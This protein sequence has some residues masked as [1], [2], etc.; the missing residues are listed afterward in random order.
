MAEYKKIRLISLARWTSVA[1]LTWLAANCSGSGC[2]SCS[3]MHPIPGGFPLSKR[4]EN[5]IQVRVTKTGVA[6][7]EQHADDILSGLM[8]NG[9]EFNITPT[10]DQD[11]SGFGSFDLCGQGDATHCTADDPPCKTHVELEELH[12]V[13]TAPASVNIDTRV[14]IWTLSSMQ[15][16]GDNWYTPDC[17]I[18]LDTRN[19]SHTDLQVV[20]TLTFNQD[21]QSNRTHMDIASVTIP[22][23]EL[24]DEDVS[25]GGGLACDTVELFFKS[26]I[27]DEVRQKIADQIAPMLNS[28]CITCDATDPQC[29]QLSSCK[30]VFVDDTPDATP[31][32]W[33]MEKSENGCVQGLGME[34]RMDVGSLLS[35]LSPPSE[36]DLDIE[37]WAGGYTEA[38]AEG[39]SQGL[40]AG[41]LPY[42]EHAS[43]VPPRDPP[44]YAQVPRSQVFDTNLRPTDNQPY[45][46]GVGIHQ[47]FLD[48]VGYALY[49]SGGLCLE[50]GPRQST[51]LTMGAIGVL[52][53]SLNDLVHDGDPGLVLAI[54]PQYAPTF[55]LGAGTSD[56]QGNIDDPLITVHAKDFA[57]DFYGFVD[58]RF[59]RLFRVL[60]DMA[61]PINLDVDDQNRLIM[62]LGSLK[63]AF[64]NIR[65][66]HS[67]LLAESHDEIAAVFPVLV[68]SAGG[69]LGNLAPIA[70]PDMFGFK[71]LLDQGSITSVD[72]QTFLAIFA[73]LA[74]VGTAPSPQRA[75][76][77]ILT[78]KLE[79][80]DRMR[81]VSL[82]D[83]ISNGPVV[84][85]DLDPTSSGGDARLEWSYRLDDGPW[86]PY[87]RSA[88]LVVRRP[89]LWVQGH[90]RIQVRAR[91]QGR[92]ATTDDSPTTTDVVVDMV[93]PSLSWHQDGHRVI[94]QGE[95][96]ISPPQ[97]LR[98]S[99]ILPDGTW[100]AWTKDPTLP[101]TDRTKPWRV[102]VRDEAGNVTESS[103]AGLYGRVQPRTSGTGACGCHSLSGNRQI[104][105]P[106][107]LVL[108]L[109]AA[110]ISARRRAKNKRRPFSSGGPA[111][112][113]L[114]VLLLGL[115]LA[116]TNQGCG[117][118]SSGGNNC[119]VTDIPLVCKDP[120]PQ[121]GPGMEPAA[122][123][124]LRL[125]PKT[126][127]PIP[128]DCHC[129]VQVGDHGRFLSTAAQ[130]GTLMV[131]CYSDRWG[132]LNVVTVDKQGQST[133][134]AVD[135]VPWDDPS[136]DDQAGFRKG[137]MQ[138]GPNVGQ[139]TDI[140]IGSDHLA[141]IS[142]VDMDSGGLKYAEGNK[143]SWTSHEVVTP[144]TDQER[145]WYTTIALDHDDTPAILFMENGIVDPTD[146][147]AFISQLKMAQAASSHPSSPTDWTITVVDQTPIPCTN[148]CASDRVCDATEWHCV[149]TDDTCD[150]TCLPT[151]ACV[152]GTCTDVLADQEWLDHPEGIGLYVSTGRLSDGRLVAA[153]H[154]RTAGTANVALYDTGTWT[155]QVVDGDAFTDR[156][157]FI[158]MAIGSDDH[159][160]LAY[161]DA[162]ADSLLYQVLDP[163]LNQLTAETVDDGLREDGQHVVGLD[164]KIVLDDSG[165]VHIFYQ[166]GTT[167]DLI[168][169][170]R[171]TD[172]Q[173]TLPP[174]QQGD[175][176][177]GFFTDL[178]RDSDGIW[179]GAQ[180][181]YDRTSTPVGSLHIWKPTL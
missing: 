2:S 3:S 113:A 136:A 45:Q 12:L 56:G 53:D 82:Q 23:G 6:F 9:L 72:G 137:I 138:K 86:S 65:V 1:L 50:M 142:Y 132:D 8:P 48:A 69:F 98:Y 116:G 181:V 68:D 29:P 63:D 64:E 131:A 81:P 42:P 159:I 172:G 76:T 73:N 160:H 59:V 87:Q 37:A 19:G 139:F 60:T 124:P 70:L 15:L 26:F 16:H 156:G 176:G 103:I 55:E 61:L 101:E 141:R 71:L 84:R 88:H 157:L 57:F 5:G 79:L 52:I 109:L 174:V 110:L 127:E 146:P 180:Y 175:P 4:M 85:I 105:G 148:L 179:W 67:E 168:E 117:G 83:A 155:T 152:A 125:D 32:H 120:V 165:A 44:P 108:L 31:Y 38:I 17:T 27:V 149:A 11:V 97:T 13:P 111:G 173:W 94:L 130:E 134:E 21:S 100:S 102:R 150:A 114:S 161:H 163:G 77:R 90:H 122:S 153:Y 43:C 145:I 75:Q 66:E 166:D 133:T 169:A 51:F 62:V 167:A 80:P 18:D 74:Y 140:A 78:T 177:F 7:V 41:G 96:A 49:D 170:S 99:H 30:E 144:A 171:Q 178:T 39:L 14:N 35:S 164:T 147:N 24:D 135:G 20:A 118:H 151:Q 25:I 123:E 34:G 91:M 54:R 107:A 104:P 58:Y 22:D 115:A 47:S 154:D 95:D 162:V 36:A 10:C 28:T 93:P 119:N 46:V 106:L 92:P 158:S 40:F 143:G 128:V 33:C 126:C 121:C 129:A 89:A 112:R